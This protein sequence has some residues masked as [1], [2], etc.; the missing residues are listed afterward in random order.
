MTMTGIG[1]MS[2]VATAAAAPSTSKGSQGSQAAVAAETSAAFSDLVA[3]LKQTVSQETT[4]NQPNGSSITTIPSVDGGSPRMVSETMN[5][6]TITQAGYVSPVLLQNF[7]TSLFQTLGSQGSAASTTPSTNEIAGSS[8][9]SKMGSS[10]DRLVAT[11]NSG[12][13]DSSL[14]GLLNSFEALMQ[15]SGIPNPD[16][17]NWTMADAR[18][19]LATFLNSAKPS[20]KDGAITSTGININEIA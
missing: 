16:G 9:K 18:S 5:G 12:A 11:L 2:S 3:M 10:V 4:V 15:G 19:A 7:L 8:V 14:Q 20:L 13:S 6:T 1:A 17:G